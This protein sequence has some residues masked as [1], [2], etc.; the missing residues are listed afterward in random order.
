MMRSEYSAGAIIYR[1]DPSGISL[2]L[3]KKEGREAYDLPKGHVERG[4]SEEAAALRE[5][6][7]ET[8]LAVNLFPYFSTSIHYIFEDH[9]ERVS[10]HVRLFLAKSGDQK[11]R[12]SEEHIAYLWCPVNEAGELLKHKEM[13]H[14]LPDI[15][16]YIDRY[17]EMHTLNSEYSRLPGSIKGWSLSKTFVP[18]EG[19]LNARIMLIGQ[20]P[21]ANEDIQKRP[22]IGRSGALLSKLLE[23]SGIGRENAYI[24]SVVQF[25]PPKNREPSKDEIALCR[26][27]IERQ[28]SIIKP[29]YVV[30]LGRVAAKAILG[31]DS[32]SDNRGKIMENNGIR[33]IITLHPSA[34]LRF[35]KNEH[36][37]KSDLELASREL[38]KDK[39]E[40]AHTISA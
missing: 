32:I 38:K 14:I 30:L 22:F 21:G 34:I 28:L 5:I 1:S 37:L 39:K 23:D 17:E 10:K 31:K 40:D 36:M 2:L 11:V 24:T 13:L 6:K 26:P 3:L 29:E 25:F 20:A 7:E 19:P 33:Y 12:I 8:G 4:E 27:F 15:R 35:P 16:D 9:K 18:G